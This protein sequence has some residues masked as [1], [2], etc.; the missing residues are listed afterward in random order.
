MNNATSLHEVVFYFLR[1]LKGKWHKSGE[2]PR[3]V[4]TCDT[5]NWKASQGKK[6]YEKHMESPTHKKN[7]VNDELKKTGYFCD[8]CQYGTTD[9]SNY[10]RHLQSE[11]HNKKER[12]KKRC[13]TFC[14]KDY[15][16]DSPLK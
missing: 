7:L 15:N 4:F 1:Y 12:A 3:E 10:T 8:L 2:G 14:A 16:V 6:L 11:K 5:C 13:G 9:S